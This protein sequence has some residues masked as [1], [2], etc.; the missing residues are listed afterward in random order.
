MAQVEPSQLGDNPGRRRDTAGGGAVLDDRTGS[1]TGLRQARRD[2][3][4]V[5][6]LQ[7][8]PGQRNPDGYRTLPGHHY[9]SDSA[10][11]HVISSDPTDD[12][13]LARPPL[14]RKS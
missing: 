9:R 1:E 14:R 4:R 3:H 2:R 11:A 13:R 8:E 6:W 7:E 5:L 10:P 12:L